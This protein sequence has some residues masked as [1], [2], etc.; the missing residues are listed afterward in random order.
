MKLLKIL[1]KQIIEDTEVLIIDDSDDV[2]TFNVYKN[3]NYLNFL[4]YYKGKKEGFD[5]A[6]IKALKLSKGRFVWWFGDD[7]IVENGYEKI[8]KIIKVKDLL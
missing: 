4:K 1:S 2:N 5:Q 7:I 3:F 8:I 6:I